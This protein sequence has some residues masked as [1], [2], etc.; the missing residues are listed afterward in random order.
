[1]DIARSTLYHDYCIIIQC[2][3]LQKASLSVEALWTSFVTYLEAQYLPGATYRAKIAFDWNAQ[4]SKI[5]WSITLYWCYKAVVM[6]NDPT[7]LGFWLNVI[8]W[9]LHVFSSCCFLP[10]KVLSL[11]GVRGERRYAI[12]PNDLQPSILFHKCVHIC[13][14]LVCAVAKLCLTVLVCIQLY[15]IQSL[16]K[17]TYSGSFLVRYLLLSFLL[18]VCL[19]ICRFPYGNLQWPTCLPRCLSFAFMLPVLHSEGLMLFPGNSSLILS[20]PIQIPCHCLI[21]FKIPGIYCITILM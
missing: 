9:N 1:M 17:K 3:L 2:S 8:K 13:G 14:A 21:F 6:A 16:K 7:T 20:L 5:Q 15:V 12:S 4:S 11:S 10:W 18:R 19:C